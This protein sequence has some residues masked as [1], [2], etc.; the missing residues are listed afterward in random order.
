MS[1]TIY[2]AQSSKSAT[3][4]KLKAKTLLGAKRE[5]WAWITEQYTGVS[6]QIMDADGMRQT[7]AIKRV[8]S[9]TGK[10]QAWQNWG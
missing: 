8:D 7:V 9:I 2:Y 3:F 1:K 6:I 4:V 5:A 10:V